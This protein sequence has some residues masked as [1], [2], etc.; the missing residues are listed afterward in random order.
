M[1][2]KITA[3]DIQKLIASHNQENQEALTR[4]SARII[5]QKQELSK[6]LAE[7][8]VAKDTG[9]STKDL[10]NKAKVRDLKYWYTPLSEIS[11]YDDLPERVRNFLEFYKYLGDLV[12][13]DEAIPLRGPN[14]GRGSL[15][16]LEKWLEG[17]DEKLNQDLK[18]YRE[19]EA[20]LRHFDEKIVN[21][22]DGHIFSELQYELYQKVRSI[23]PEVHTVGEL[24]TSEVH[25]HLSERDRTTIN[26]YLRQFGAYLRLGM[27][28]PYRP[29]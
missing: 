8:I 10:L 17:L 6:L 29:S 13:L 5:E 4:L 20:L 7:Y 27:S 25:K 23:A 2:S 24:A 3:K 21:R 11:G 28:P 22:E 15:T 1:T 12:I 9:A 19:N 18:E 26:A 14:F 16:K